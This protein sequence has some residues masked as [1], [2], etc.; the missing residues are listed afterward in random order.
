MEDKF[1]GGEK[2]GKEKER[3]EK[4]AVVAPVGQE[5]IIVKVNDRLGTA[6]QIPC[7]ASDPISEW[8]FCF[9]PIWLMKVWVGL[10]VLI[11][12]VL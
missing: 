12:A 4:K 9:C 3:K 5:M 2:A 7:L 6:A 1:G 11:C 8:K 10:L